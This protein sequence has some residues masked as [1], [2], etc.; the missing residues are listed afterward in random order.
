MKRNLVTIFFI[1]SKIIGLGAQ[2]PVQILGLS[3]RIDNPS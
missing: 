3:T 1:F 2:T